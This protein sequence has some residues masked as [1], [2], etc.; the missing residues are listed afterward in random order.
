M[1]ENKRIEKEL[2][3]KNNIKD[4][5]SISLDSD[6]KIEKQELTGCFL[7]SGDYKVHEVSLNR[8]KF[9][10]KIPF[11]ESIDSNIDLDTVNVE[12]TNFLYDYKKDELMVNID[13]EITGER[14]D[15]LIFD[16]EESL[17]EFLNSRE[18]EVVDTRLE[19]IKE[20]IITE[21]NDDEIIE[22]KEE[23]II[24]DKCDKEGIEKVKKDIEKVNINEKKEIIEILE[25][26]NQEE[27]DVKNNLDDEDKDILSSDEIISNVNKI[28]DGF[29]T[30][31]VY[32]IKENETLESIVI[33]NKTTIDELKEYNDLNNLSINDKIIIP[34]YE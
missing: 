12:I 29:V 34:V 9:N 2:L 14:K 32:K 11:K 21:E 18:V 17:D 33:K 22:V 1:K 4:I 27:M 6:F 20:E 19:E 26:N 25:R 31:K 8:E 30:Y 28:Q 10:F 13:Y 3:F 24:L 15:V 23:K 7:I 16:D 5:T